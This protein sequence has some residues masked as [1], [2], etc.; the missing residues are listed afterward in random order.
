MTINLV[1][2]DPSLKR[3]SAPI[4]FDEYDSGCALAETLEETL[5]RKMDEEKGLGIAAPQIGYHYQC[6]LVGNTFMVNPRV[7]IL[8]YDTDVISEGCLSFPGLFVEVERPRDIVVA[9]QD[10]KGKEHTAQLTGIDARCFLHEKEH[11]DGGVFF[12][13]ASRLQLGRAIKRAKKLGYLYYYHD[14]MKFTR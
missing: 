10:S 7:M 5:R 14:L 4:H 1:I 11:L 8:G 6:M 13:N 9:Y 12:R 2:N 3:P